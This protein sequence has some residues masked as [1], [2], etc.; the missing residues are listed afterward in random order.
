[1]PRFHVLKTIARDESFE[2]NASREGSADYF[3]TGSVLHFPPMNQA[4]L[5]VAAWSCMAAM[6]APMAEPTRKM[7]L[8]GWPE[9]GTCACAAA[10]ADWEAP[11]VRASALRWLAVSMSM[12]TG[13]ASSDKKQPSASSPSDRPRKEARFDAC[14]E[15]STTASGGG[16]DRSNPWESES[17][18][19]S[20]RTS[21]FVGLHGRRSKGMHWQVSFDK[22]SLSVSAMKRCLACNCPSLQ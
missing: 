12:E 3:F 16:G 14:L 17:I 15:P 8:A 2:G 10:I 21:D 19:A 22:Q 4:E 20:G 9:V 7:L 11:A 1:M 5:R 13:R 18:F 6:V